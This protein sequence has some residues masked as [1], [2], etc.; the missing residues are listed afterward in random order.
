MDYKKMYQTVFDEL[1]PCSKMV[2][3]TSV[4]DEVS[5]RSM[6]IIIHQ[7]RFY[8]Q[9][10]TTMDKTKEIAQNPRVALCSK[11]TSIMG[12]CKEIGKPSDKEN[13]W[14]LDKFRTHFEN[15][16]MK[17]S[18]L[19]HERVYEIVP[20]KIKLWRPKGDLPGLIYLD[21]ENESC[22]VEKIE[23]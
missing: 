10:S 3:A 23:L 15:A 17:Y 19:E 6:S 2:L 12:V 4:N 9:T 18:H 11:G 22:R 20:T 14:F 13:A 21:C 1:G 7:G 5:A 8:F 16:F